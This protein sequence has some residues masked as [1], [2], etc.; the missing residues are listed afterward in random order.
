MLRPDLSS[1][2]EMSWLKSKSLLVMGDIFDAKHQ[3]KLL[4]IS[5]RNILRNQIDELKKLGK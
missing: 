1:I 4:A 3:E 2:R 5:P